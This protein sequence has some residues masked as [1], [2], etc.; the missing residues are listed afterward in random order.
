M[1]VETTIPAF[2]H[3]I[4]GEDNV[5]LDNL[6]YRFGNARRRAYSLK[7][8]NIP[9]KHIER[10]LQTET[11]LNSRYIK[12]A[13]YTI[14]DLPPHVTFGGLRNQRLREKGKIT[15]EELHYKRNSILYSRGDHTKKGNL[16]IRLIIENG[17]KKL[18][19][20]DPINN[21]YVFV[22]VFIPDKYW[23]KY[24]NRL[25]GEYPYSIMMKRK[26]GKYYVYFQIR[27]P[28]EEKINMKR[29]MSLDINAGHLD[30]SVMDKTKEKLVEVG[31]IHI[32]ETQ[33][34]GSGKR[35]NICW[36]VGN[37]IS[38]ISNHFNAE[39]V[40]GKL[41]TG[42]YKG[43]ANRVI[44]NI[45]QYKIRKNIKQKVNERGIK[46]SERSEAYT[47]KIGKQLSKRIGLDVHKCSAILFGLKYVNYPLFKGLQSE[48]C[49]NEG[50]GSQTTK[51]MVGSELTVPIQREKQSLGDDET[52]HVVGGGYSIIPDNWGL[53]V[54]ASNMK[55][56]LANHNICRFVKLS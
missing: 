2:I 49:G 37:K 40:V 42:K 1:Q 22:D 23:N 9:K 50:N 17:E 27:K 13:Y 3:N 45:P 55:R 54:F 19:I 48:A 34:C 24:S 11:G 6:F 21:E 30:Y 47:S 14:K 38:N 56:D 7:Q 16:N 18:R 15:K 39:V 20:K 44:H 43:G 53:D 36:K 26:N 8:K 33:Y 5:C 35:D 12:D 28:I 32:P 4:S 52:H 29:V 31:K 10:D 51:R 46:V 41:N 25:T